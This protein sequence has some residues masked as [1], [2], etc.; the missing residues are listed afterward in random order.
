MYN[1]IFTNRKQNTGDREFIL[2]EVNSVVISKTGH[3]VNMCI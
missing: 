3:S 2:T 1:S